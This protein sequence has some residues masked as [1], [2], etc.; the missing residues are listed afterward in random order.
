MLLWR[1]QQRVS[2]PEAILVKRW[3][4][5]GPVPL[6]K[7]C[8]GARIAPPHVKNTTSPMTTV[9]TRPP[10]LLGRRFRLQIVPSL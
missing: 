5:A 4:R 3:M 8:I 7:R 10:Q 6:G 2:P 9:H 1:G